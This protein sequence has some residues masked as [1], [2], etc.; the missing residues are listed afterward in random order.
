MNRVPVAGATGLLGRFVGLPRLLHRPR[1]PNFFLE[2]GDGPFRFLHSVAVKSLEGS[3][4]LVPGD[5]DH[6]VAQADHHA[7]P[8]ALRFGLE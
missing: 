1:I 4:Q 7:L 2:R 5:E 6:V 8:N 3:P